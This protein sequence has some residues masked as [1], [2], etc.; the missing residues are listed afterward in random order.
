MS[1]HAEHGTL[2][3]ITSFVQAANAQPMH[4]H[5]DLAIT[6][7]IVSILQIVCPIPTSLQ[8]LNFKIQILID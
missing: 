5:S 8:D 3:S 4:R 1:L 2:A 6:S 7:N